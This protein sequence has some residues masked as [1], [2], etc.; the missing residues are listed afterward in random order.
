MKLS[1]SLSLTLPFLC[2]ANAQRKI[3]GGFIET[4][5]TLYPKDHGIVTG[6][7]LRLDKQRV[8][9]CASFW[10]TWDP[11][12]PS[13]PE[14]V[15]LPPDPGP[16]WD[17]V[18]YQSDDCIKEIDQDSWPWEPDENYTDWDYVMGSYILTKEPDAE[19]EII[20]NMASDDPNTSAG[21]CGR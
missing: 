19:L 20:T 17:V 6:E 11:F 10:A 2:V 8:G 5:F 13:Q 7:A 3:D 18:L 16:G 12:G 1:T 14:T 15:Y 21:K 4:N 9:Q